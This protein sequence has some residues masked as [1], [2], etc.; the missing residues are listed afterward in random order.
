[1]KRV[2]L[3][4]NVLIAALF[5]K[6]KPRTIYELVKHRKLIMLISTDMEKEFIRV[7]GYKKFGLSSKEIIPFIREIRRHAEFVNTTSRISIIEADPTDNIFLECGIDGKADYIISGDKHL[8]TLRSFE[9]I[10]ILNANEFL[11]K[12]NFLKDENV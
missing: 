5:W 1:M 10:Q 6:G 3:D 2:V 4:T 12:E 8:L 9:G 7:L 11:I